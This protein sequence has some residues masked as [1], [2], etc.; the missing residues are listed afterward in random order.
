MSEITKAEI[1][2]FLDPWAFVRPRSKVATKT[3]TGKELPLFGESKLL[4]TNLSQSV[5][6]LGTAYER[7][8]TILGNLNSIKTFAQEAVDSGDSEARDEN[9]AKIRSL[10]AG[11]DVLVDQS[12]FD[13]QRLLDGSPSTFAA[14]QNGKTQ[15][16]ELA[17]ILTFG[18]GSL[19]LSQYEDVARVELFFSA[20][21]DMLNANRSTLGIDVRAAEFSNPEDP[22]DELEDGDYRIKV[23]YAGDKSVVHLTDQALKPIKTIEN[24]DLSGDGEEIIDFGNGVKILIDK[25][26]VFSP[27]GVD[28]WDYEKRGSVDYFADVSYTR[29]AQQSLLVDSAESLYRDATLKSAVNASTPEGGKLTFVSPT[30]GTPSDDADRLEDGTYTVKVN[31]FGSNSS[32]SLKDSSGRIVKFVSGVDLGQSG[33]NQIDFGNGLVVNL[34]NQQVG[35]TPKQLS[36]TVAIESSS[37][38][39]R[40]APSFD[41]ENANTLLSETGTLSIT[42]MDAGINP[43]SSKALAKGDYSIEL[44]YLGKNSVATLRN[45]EGNIVDF[46][47]NLDLSGEGDN[48]VDL[49]NGVQLTVNNSS[50]GSGS[51]TLTADFK[52][53][54]KPRESNNDD[55]DTAAIAKFLKSESL[56][57]SEGGKISISGF[58]TGDVDTGKEALTGGKYTVEINY[59]GK[60]SVVT[61][62]D[63]DGKRIQFNAPVDLSGEGES[64]VAF[65]NGLNFIFNNEGYTDWGKKF[66]AEVD[67]TPERTGV[68]AGFD[69]E[70]YV[71]QVDQAMEVVE[72]QMAIIDEVE[73]QINGQKRFQDAL[74]QEIRN[75]SM[76]RGASTIQILSAGVDSA[77]ASI[78]QAGS[79]NSQAAVNIQMILATAGTSQEP[80]FTAADIISSSTNLSQN[81]VFGILSG[82]G[83]PTGLFG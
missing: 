8:N 14:T 29:V 47:A 54:D 67:Y 70:A 23:S 4:T 58:S 43:A 37:K 31:Y 34:N 3:A 74:Q 82:Q 24:V 19:E 21:A 11:I 7:L 27:P 76:M 65:G 26:T 16:L 78:F 53:I 42:A 20:G 9:Y 13:N 5:N 36:A 52:I 79:A 68:S 2:E 28:K 73:F 50:F 72:E 63:E 51:G 62:L 6:V 46:V 49:G 80:N 61:L 57:D 81:S 59:Y 40:V 45:D 25:T 15:T 44:K 64:E 10:T 35:A 56:K 66:R 41:A 30:M 38:S 71:N 75:A 22:E 69:F 12:R 32:A 1:Q 83:G 55:Q 77:S 17:N 60:N 18:E 33:V 39:T 48:I